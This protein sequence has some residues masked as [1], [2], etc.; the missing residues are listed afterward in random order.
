VRPWIW[1]NC[2]LF[3]VM[4]IWWHNSMCSWHLNSKA[5]KGGGE[6]CTDNRQCISNVCI[7]GGG[8]C[9]WRR[10]CE[11][12]YECL[13]LISFSCKHMALY[14]AHFNHLPSF[15]VCRTLPQRWKQLALLRQTPIH[16]IILTLFFSL[17]APKP[18]L[19]PTPNVS[20]LSLTII[21]LPSSFYCTYVWIE[22][23]SQHL[24]Q[25]RR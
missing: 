20:R 23:P 17:L 22:W 18:T 8:S 16:S 14:L 6:R 25:Q 4:I 7:K 9:E 5:K 24:T 2:L 15:A 1:D 12:S 19:R 3:Q 11:V 21:F 13:S 10:C